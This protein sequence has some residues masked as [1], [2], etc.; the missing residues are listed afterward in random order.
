[1]SSVP[2]VR[3]ALKTLLAPVMLPFGVQV[4][5]GSPVAVTT[6]DED[7]LVIG[8]IEGVR[9]AGSQNRIR[10]TTR[11]IPFG[12]SQDEYTVEMI[13]AVSRPGPGETT[14]V[15]TI[16]DQIFEAVRDAVEGSGALGVGGVFEA[17]PTDSFAFEPNADSN[18]RYVT[19]TFGI[20]VTARD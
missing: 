5:D 10:T 8:R 1:M 3:A 15:V 16:A 14:A 7:V 6:L 20:D 4:I 9:S 2:A 17:L 11:N 18:G 12:T 13:L 19:V